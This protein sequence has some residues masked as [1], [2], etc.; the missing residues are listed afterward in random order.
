MF[1]SVWQTL[2]LLYWISLVLKPCSIVV[3]LDITGSFLGVILS[4]LEWLLTP[5]RLDPF[6]L[7]IPYHS[8]KA[9]DFMGGSNFRRTYLK[10]L[11][12]PLL[13]ILKMEIFRTLVLLEK[14]QNSEPNSLHVLHTSKVFLGMTS[15]ESSWGQ[16]LSKGFME[17][18]GDLKFYRL[19]SHTEFEKIFLLRPQGIFNLNHRSSA[20]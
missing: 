5:P 17:C 1:R 19:N 10:H 4:F 20:G 18:C 3:I 16:L 12:S 13:V 6:Y 14:L 7:L 9:A 2:C 11:R 15:Y 8:L